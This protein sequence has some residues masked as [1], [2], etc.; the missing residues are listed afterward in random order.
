MKHVT[1]TEEFAKSKLTARHV[2]E[3]DTVTRQAKVDDYNAGGQLLRSETRPAS[4]GELKTA[5]REALVAR[6]KGSANPEVR[7]LLS[8]I[9][10]E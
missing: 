2:T 9:L 7:D 6:L 8:L 4:A 3:V 1:T 5:G 10:N